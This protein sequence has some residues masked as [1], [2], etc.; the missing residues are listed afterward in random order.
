[1]TAGG[2]RGQTE[3]KKK[4]KKKES[5]FTGMRRSFRKGGGKEPRVVIFEERCV[6]G[7]Q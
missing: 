7:E 4:R 2:G 1:M 3:R 6:L 5:K